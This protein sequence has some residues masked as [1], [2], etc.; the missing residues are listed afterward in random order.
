[1]SQT[2]LVTEHVSVPE[3]P[4]KYKWTNKKQFANFEEADMLRNTLKSEG[5]IVKVRRCGPR[6]TQFKV[7]VASEI[8]K[9]KKSKGGKNAAK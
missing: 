9:N 5:Q 3:N 2:T 6:G 1:M 8:Q 4:Q 7:V